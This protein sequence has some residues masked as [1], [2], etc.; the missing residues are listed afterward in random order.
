LSTLL[1]VSLAESLRLCMEKNN[2]QQIISDYIGNPT[3]QPILLCIYVWNSQS[4]RVKLLNYGIEP[5]LKVNGVAF[6][7]E[8]IIRLKSTHL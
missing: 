6:Y 2:Y 1:S 3:S 8:N 7:F 4:Q 5:T